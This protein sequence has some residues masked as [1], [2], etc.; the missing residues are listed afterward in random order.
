MEYDSGACVTLMSKLFF[1][2][3]FQANEIEVSN[4]NL[5][6]VTGEKVSVLGSAEVNVWCEFDQSWKI[7]SIVVV[8]VENDFVPLLGR[9]WLDILT[10][11]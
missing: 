4:K 6:V 9:N 11:N 3:H 8:D 1:D 7:L 10:P 5:K 2:E